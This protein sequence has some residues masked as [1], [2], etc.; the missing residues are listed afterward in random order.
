M[1]V[2]FR[3]GPL[4]MYAYI[5]ILLLGKPGIVYILTQGPV[6]CI[7]ILLLCKPGIVYMLTHLRSDTTV[8]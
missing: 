7:L 4:T 2:F 3:M 5:L 1:Y 8:F 6:A